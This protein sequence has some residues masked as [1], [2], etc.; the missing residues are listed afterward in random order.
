MR[1][2]DWTS[3]G[4][5]MLGAL[6]WGLVGIFHFNLVAAILGD[7]TSAARVVYILVALAAVYWIVGLRAIARRTYLGAASPGFERTHPTI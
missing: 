2:A 4:L 1:T 3:F 6:N 5:V 7:G